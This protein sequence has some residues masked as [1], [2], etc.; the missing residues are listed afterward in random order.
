MI[1]FRNF[2]GGPG[3]PSQ[4]AVLSEMIDKF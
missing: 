2:V 1:K 4:K 3:C